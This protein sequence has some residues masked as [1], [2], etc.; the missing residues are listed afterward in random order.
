MECSSPKSPFD[1][2]DLLYL[3]LGIHDRAPSTDFGC[4]EYLTLAELWNVRLLS[5][6]LYRDLSWINYTK[7]RDGHN[8]RVP[9]PGFPGLLSTR[10]DAMDQFVNGNRIST[11][12][13]GL[14]SHQLASLAAMHRME[15]ASQEFGALRGGIL[16]DAPGLGKTITMLG[17][18]SSTAGQR[19]T[20]PAEFWD[21]SQISEG[22]EA[23][24]QNPTL[25]MELNKALKPIR[26]WLETNKYTSPAAM[27]SFKQML[28]AI[29]CP[30]PEND[31]FPTILSLE[32]FIKQW[33][34]RQCHVPK[35]LVVETV[36]SQMLQIKAGLDKSNRKLLMSMVGRRLKQERSMLPSSATLIVVPDSLLEHWFQQILCHL[37]LSRFVDE[38]GSKLSKSNKNRG[39]VYIDGIGD[40]V[41]ARIPLKGTTSSL[42]A[43]QPWELSQYHIVITCF[44]RC[45]AEYNRLVDSGHLT[46]PDDESQNTGFANSNR[47][48]Q[49][50]QRSKW[51]SS[52]RKRLRPG[53]ATAVQGSDS[54]LTSLVRIRWLRLVVDEGHELGI[55]EARNG[56]TRFIHEIAAE[57]RWVMSG[58]PT[59][60]NEDDQDFAARTLDQLQ[61]LFVF[62]RH[63]IYGD[64]P[65][66][67]S[68]SSVYTTPT[69]P[70]SEKN[71]LERKRR[72]KQQWTLM[73]KEPF[74][75]KRT[76]GRQRL[77]T[78]LKE[79]MVMHRKEDINL[80]KPIF[81]Q[82]DVDVPIPVNIQ[83]KI[84]DC[85]H[86]SVGI[87][88]LD[89]Y[90]HSDAYQSLVDKAQ[91]EYIVS[92]I[93]QA[94]QALTERGGPLTANVALQQHDIGSAK[95]LRP[96][97]AV[98]FSS[99]S[100]VLLSVTD[101]LY[102]ML[103][104]ENVAELY[105]NSRV[106]DLSREISRFRNGIKEQRICPVCR[107][108][109]DLEETH[110]IQCGHMLIE[111]V[112]ESS[113]VGE[114]QPTRFLIEPER[115]RNTPNVPMHRM[116][117]ERL[118]AYNQNQRFWRIGDLLEVDIR[119][120]HPV[121]ALRQDE[122]AWEFYGSP[123][124]REL[125][126]SDNYYGPD[127]Y[128]GPL[129]VANSRGDGSD[130]N[131]IGVR[132]MKWQ[133]CGR[134]HNHTR[135]YRGPRLVDAEIRTIQED[136]FVLCLDANLA[137]GL[138]LSFVTHMFLLEAIDDAALLEQVTS[139]AHRLGATGPVVIDTVNTF[140][141]IPEETE[142]ALQDVVDV[143][144]HLKPEGS[145]SPSFLTKKRD[146]DRRSILKR[147]VCQ[148]C[149]RQ[150]MSMFEAEE[151][152]RLTCPRNPDS[153]SVLD[154]FHL[155]SIY[156][157][158]RP[159]EALKADT[160]VAFTG[161]PT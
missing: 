146:Y 123:K 93:Q 112:A 75:Q 122:E 5:Q 110:T 154:P 52:A 94:K 144:S 39:V 20:T 107:R 136:V 14:Y 31:K 129:P 64:V 156:E 11:A 150:F 92:K 77:E 124:C 86:A 62:L 88:M 13:P 102:R 40:I 30:Y 60:G 25:N 24:R 63:P 134:Y 106:G 155:S 142:L 12:S 32:R 90:L 79:T 149:Y 22:W 47:K 137:T 74:L 53:A 126:E 55:H 73:V 61:R 78:I 48:S 85:G 44:S 114:G 6:S 128:F 104:T 98:V 91:A 15:N 121:L 26:K 87:A 80:P 57:R 51:Q 125:A 89:E 9:F 84:R 130:S 135:W 69:N 109:N 21:S 100:N 159:P 83:C 82:A 145:N 113:S 147:A 72:A 153:Q 59:T 23:L 95:D 27:A 138:D 19:P 42:P 28:T 67:E 10:Q 16:G 157:T 29:C 161:R 139:R 43:P 132:L 49:R 68:S 115:I 38:D 50:L 118:S 103:S 8:Y 116:G 54:A 81:L 108:P 111:V 117:G 120:P 2:K 18:I 127:W 70:R 160:A 66:P 158:I 133:K 99:D 7:C 140:Y 4:W 36:R 76:E 3:F 34:V 45:E 131:V 148:Y 71:D 143:D 105:G 97:K 65:F 101:Q 35:G 33:L 119:N 58:T 141:K 17:L 1:P 151:H 152:E 96:I 41:N 37:E 56:V 46:E